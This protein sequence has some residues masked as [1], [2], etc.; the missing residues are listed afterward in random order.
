MTTYASIIVLFC[1]PLAITVFAKTF[2][3][4]SAPPEQARVIQSIHQ[5][6]VTSPFAAAF[7]VPLSGD[8]SSEPIRHRYFPQ[9]WGMFGAHVFTALGIDAILALAMIYLL[10][11]RYRVSQSGDGSAAPSTLDGPP[12][13]SLP[14]ATLVE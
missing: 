5:L 12:V 10:H 3:L 1:V 6:G 13:E 9:S 8:E 11:A 14:T 7:S 2:M 4:E